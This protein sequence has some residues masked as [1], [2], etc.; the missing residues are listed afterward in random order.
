[1]RHIQPEDCGF[2]KYP[3]DFEKFRFA[4]STIMLKDRVLK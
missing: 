4:V 1:M 3:V 2:D